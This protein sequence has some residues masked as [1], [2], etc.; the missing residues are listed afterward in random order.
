MDPLAIL[1]LVGALVLAGAWIGPRIRVATPLVQLTL[2]VAVGFVPIVREIELPSEAV[3]VLFLPA[4]LF[5]ESLNTPLREIRR[6]LRGILILSTV[7]VAASAFGVGGIGVLLGLGWGAALVLGAALAPTDATA[8]ESMAKGLPQRNMTVLRAES[9]INDGSAL[10][11][12]SIAV[13]VAASEVAFTGWQITGLVALAYVGGAAVG[14]AAGWLGTQVLRRLSDP[15]TNNTAIVL[16]PFAA[17]FV[18]ET[19]DASGVVAVV[20]AGL[21]LTQTGPRATSPLSRQQNVGFWSLTT[22]LLN[23]ALFVLIGIEAQIAV[24]DVDP[25]TI[26]LLLALTALAWIAV[27]VIRFA[28]HLLAGTLISILERRPEERARQMSHR[29]RIVSSV[30]GFRGAVSLAVALSVPSAVAERD[31]IIFVATG[32]VLL[33]LVVQGMLLGPAIRWANFAPDTTVDDE[34]VKAQH[35]ATERTRGEIKRLAREL[36]VSDAVRDRVREEYHDYLKAVAAT[37]PDGDRATA[38]ENEDYVALRLAL[39]EGKR[40][41]MI[42][43]RDEGR[44]SDATLRILQTRLDREALRLDQ[45]DPLE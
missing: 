37:E 15:I 18:A 36:G 11:I 17:Y 38:K 20:I 4:L 24:R 35:E 32:V 44:I 8:V 27:L 31:E 34:I 16:V 5:W 6:D 13:A 26:P 33:T 28:F 7:L 2:G 23:G 39:I 29:E 42:R 21:L 30:A 14:L 45:P 43:L 40:E 19:I 10:V 22:S 9:L 3:L 25:G 41:V 12:Y 1:V